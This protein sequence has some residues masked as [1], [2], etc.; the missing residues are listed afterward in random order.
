VTAIALPRGSALFERNARAHRSHWLVIFSGFFEPLF[1]LLSMGVGLGHFVGKVPGPNGELISYASFIAPALL[2]TAAMNGAIYD[3]TSVF[4][5]M[6]YMKLYDSVL[7]TPLGPLDVAVGEMGW[8]L[9]RGL[10]YA[11]AFLS[12]V[13]VLGLVHSGWAILALPSALLV[14]FAFAGMGMAGATHMRSWQDFEFVALIQLPMFLFSAT[15]FPISTY[16]EAIQ[17]I[18]RF[19]PLYHAIR[20]LRALNFGV[21]DWAQ[22]VDLAYLLALGLLGVYIAQRRLAKLLLK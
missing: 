21:V 17:W 10:L 15:F 4:W 5:K 3:S 8:A 11:I 16:P 2:A 22:A 9:F 6:K 7:S 1:Y 12:T 18:V 19:S 13:A 20:L 14:G